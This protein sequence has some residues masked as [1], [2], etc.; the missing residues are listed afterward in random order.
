M[1]YLNDDRN[2]CMPRVGYEDTR[3]TPPGRAIP[4]SLHQSHW[5]TLTYCSVEVKH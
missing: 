4:L 2:S 3:D 1:T 5:F